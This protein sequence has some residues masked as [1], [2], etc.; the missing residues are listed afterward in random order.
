MVR[1][2]YNQ[3]ISDIQLL[4]SVIDCIVFWTKNPI[5]MLNQMDRLKNYPYYFQ[6]TLTGYGKDLEANPPQ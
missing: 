5:P 4:R 2:P 3:Q 1:N 6:M